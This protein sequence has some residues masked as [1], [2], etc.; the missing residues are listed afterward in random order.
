MLFKVSETVYQ[1]STK[2]QHELPME[3]SLFDQLKLLRKRLA[4]S[5]NVPPYVIFSDATLQE[6]ATYLP[7]N[8]EDLGEISGFGAVKLEKYGEPFLEQVVEYC[9][10]KG[11]KSQ[12]DKKQKK[13]KKK[14]NLKTPTMLESIR[15]LR[16]GNTPG[17]IAEKRD[18]AISTVEG[19]L[20]DG[21]LEGLV[22]ILEVMPQELVDEI[23][24]VIMENTIPGLKPVKEKLREDITYGQIRAVYNSLQHKGAVQ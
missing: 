7:L 17:K 11:I 15:L 19:H 20:N 2:P 5:E 16:E 13:R 24:P 22:D 9:T 4:V 8:Q 3:A 12:M 1:S 23:T 18:L 6:L 21:I 10:T 14:S